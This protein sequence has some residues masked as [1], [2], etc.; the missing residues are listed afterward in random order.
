[1]HLIILKIAFKDNIPKD[2]IYVV[3]LF[4]LMILLSIILKKITNII[5]R[6]ISKYENMIFMVNNEA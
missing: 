2:S 4:P 3:T 1:M 5:I 6:M